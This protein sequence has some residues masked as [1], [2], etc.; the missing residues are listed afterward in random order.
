MA[1]TGPAGV[2][3]TSFRYLEVHVD[4]HGAPEHAGFRLYGSWLSSCNKYTME[5]L[6]N[7]AHHLSDPRNLA[8]LG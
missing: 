8:G 3:K 5:G 4:V 2:T 1:V 6:H 7:N